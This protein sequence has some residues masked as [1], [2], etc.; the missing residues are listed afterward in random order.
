LSENASEYEF[1]AGVGAAHDNCRQAC[2][3]LRQRVAIVEDN[4]PTD[5]DKAKVISI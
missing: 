1:L 5:L 4:G 3:E 2:A